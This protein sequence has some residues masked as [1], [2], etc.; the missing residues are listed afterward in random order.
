MRVYI[1]QPIESIIYLTISFAG[2][3][4]PVGVNCNGGP[5]LLGIVGVRGLEIL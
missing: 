2:V 1:H 4:M 3:I 5:G